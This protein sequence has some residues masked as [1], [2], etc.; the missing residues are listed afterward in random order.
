MTTH[1][2]EWRWGFVATSAIVILTALPQFLFVIDRGSSW[3]GSNAAMHADEVAYSDYVASIIRGRPRRNDPFT[4]RTDHS[5]SP[6][7]ESL[8]SIQVIPPY[9]S[10]IPARFLGLSASSVFIV[11][12]LLLAAASSLALFWFMSLLTRDG[13]LSAS[14]VCFIF[15]FGTLIARQGIL[16]YV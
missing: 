8:F 14:A 7:P 2:T 1:R 13:R 10:A 6:V 15:G 4:G 5:A 9:L 12:P 11:G 16:R 3:H